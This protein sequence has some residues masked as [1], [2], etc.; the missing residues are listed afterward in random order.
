MKKLLMLMSVAAVM[1]AIADE[2]RFPKYV[3]KPLPGLHDKASRKFAG[4][5]SLAVAENGRLWCT[6][7]AGPTPAEDTNNYV[8]LSTSAD[9]G[10]TW[11][12]VLVVDPDGPGD[13]RAFDSE[14]WAAPDGTLR[15]TW[16]DRVKHIQST[17]RTWMLTLPDANELPPDALPEPYAFG[18][19]V[20]MNKILVRSNGEWL[21]PICRWFTE[22][23]SG[24][25]VSTDGGKT[26]VRRGGATMP[27]EDRL[28]DEHNFIE[29]P[30]GVLRVY[31]RTKSGVREAESTD[32]GAT[33]SPME[34]C[35]T[36]KHT[37]SRFRVERLQSG[38]LLLIKNGPVN[39]DVGRKQ[40]MAFISRDNGATWEGGLM[41][42]ERGTTS[43]PSCQQRKDG[44]IFATY[45][46]NRTTEMEIHWAA[47]TEADVLA[48]RDVSG[49]VQLK[50]IVSAR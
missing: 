21:A 26:F 18:D 13:R 6:W 9:E 19:G 7:Y 23:S 43:Y 34:V 39:K 50:G 20:M 46:R 42:D 29:L 38:N 47:F 27:K 5:S 1:T 28:F 48:G 8:V 10:K 49:K 31:A 17:C 22:G 33:W 44:V 24:A 4:I 40:M 16:C 30:N 45:D 12:E 41:L 3:G 25:Y 32:G 37:S 15:L 2:V 36:F 14:V 11:T 35:K